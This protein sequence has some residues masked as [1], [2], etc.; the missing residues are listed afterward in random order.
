MKSHRVNSRVCFMTQT[1]YTK[2]RK[3]KENDFLPFF[4]ASLTVFVFPSLLLQTVIKEA[5]LYMCTILPY[6]QEE[7]VN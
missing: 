5:V 3:K 2:E 1:T 4:V 6:K 7:M